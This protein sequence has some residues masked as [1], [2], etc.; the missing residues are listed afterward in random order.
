V[1]QGACLR[2]VYEYLTAK[3]ERRAQF[4]FCRGN[5]NCTHVKSLLRNVG[6]VM[7]VEANQVSFGFFVR[8]RGFSWRNLMKVSLKPIQNLYVNIIDNR[9]SERRP[10]LG[11]GKSDCSL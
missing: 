2:A 5:N 6:H 11:K 1:W 3:M 9:F 7:L 10:N 4:L 8:I